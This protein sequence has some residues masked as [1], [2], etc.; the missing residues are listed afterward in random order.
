MYKA[1]MDGEVDVIT[2]FSS[3]GRIVADKL[4]VLED[5]R[6]LISPYDA[7]VMIAPTRSG[8]PILRQAL[9]PLVGAIPIERMR[10][11]NLMVDRDQDKMTPAAAAR[12]L[13][14]QAGLP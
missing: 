5:P 6:G 14:E 8:D 7:I 1:L 13:A 9:T 4:T 10:A 2:A 12:W 3:D 11:A